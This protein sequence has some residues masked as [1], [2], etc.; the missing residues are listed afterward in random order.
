MKIF[1]LISLVLFAKI[2]FA[3]TQKDTAISQTN[4]VLETTSGK[5]FG[6]LCV[7]AAAKRK[8]PVV[9]IISGSGPTD[10]NCNSNLGFT[11]N[12][13]KML[14]DSLLQYGI[15]SLRYDKRGVGESKAAGGKE[16]DL[17][18]D[19]YVNDAV[20]FIDLLKKD[21]R[22]SAVIIM[23]HSEGSLTGMLA[24]QKATVSKY[25]SVSG[26]G[27][28]LPVTLKKQISA[29]PKEIQ[30]MC[31]PIIDSLANGYNVKT[32]SPV[33]YSLFRP[34]VQPF[35]ISLFK[36]D[37]A[38]EIAKLIIPV[39]IIQGNTD[40]Q[41]SEADAEKLH[42]AIPKSEYHIIQGMSHILKDGPADP[43]KNYATYNS[44]T[45]PILSPFVQS[46]VTFINK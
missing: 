3:Q 26:P 38:I 16:E 42:Q 22:F 29:Q 9:L 36:Y 25:I 27:L 2:D 13:F 14:A 40:I 12:S 34:S 10:R 18:F 33:L 45:V 23:G 28:P 11:C 6:T 5:I 32:I 35:L 46:V 39:D 43:A 15:A 4:I 31:F 21:K 1:F 19:D 8:I 24:A 37:P 41:V 44:P 20:G 17:R 30:N 7:P